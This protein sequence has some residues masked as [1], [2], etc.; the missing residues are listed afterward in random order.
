M[1]FLRELKEAMR[2]DRGKDM[3]VHVSVCTGY[4]LNALTPAVWKLWC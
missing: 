3:S 4:D 2:F 1:I